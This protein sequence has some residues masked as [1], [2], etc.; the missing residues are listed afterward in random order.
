ML[1]PHCKKKKRKRE[2]KY[3]R[4][5]NLFVSHRGFSII[6]HNTI[7]FLLSFLHFPS[8]P[9]T[10]QE[11]KLCPL[12]FIQRPM[13]RNM[14]VYMENV[15]LSITSPPPK[16]HP[17]FSS[18]FLSFFPPIPHECTVHFHFN[19]FR[20]FFFPSL[21]LVCKLLDATAVVDACLRRRK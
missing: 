16:P 8:P 12:L 9:H 3:I 10:P 4:K 19:I 21:S 20:N 6:V 13:A 11:K 15:N 1:C 7:F 18:F 14:K 5:E 17:Q 2:G